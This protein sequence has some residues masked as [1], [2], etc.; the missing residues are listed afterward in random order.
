MEHQSPKEG[1]F[2]LDAGKPQLDL[3]PFEALKAEAEAL[4]FG[5]NKYSRHGFKEGLLTSRLAAA[6]LR[7]I[8]KWLAGA[9]KDEESGAHHLGHARASLAMLLYV[10]EHKPELDDRYKHNE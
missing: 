3:I 7:H 4:M 2:K 5:A 1:S 10:L 8:Y 9:D 6:A